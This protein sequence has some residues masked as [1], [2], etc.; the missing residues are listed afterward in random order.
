[1]QGQLQ[2]LTS[3]CILALLFSGCAK[4]KREPGVYIGDVNKTMAELSPRDVIISVNGDPLTRHEFE[5]NGKL[6]GKIWRILN[7][8]DSEPVEHAVRRREQQFIP[9]FIL[10]TMVK[11]EAK[12]RGITADPCD[13][14][15]VSTNFLKSIRR[16]GKTLQQVADEFSGEPGQKMIDMVNADALMQTLLKNLAPR[17][18]SITEADIDAAEKRIAEFDKNTAASNAVNLA[19]AKRVAAEVR[20]GGDIAA[21]AKRYSQINP[22]DGTLWGPL[23]KEQL[24]YKSPAVLAWAEKAKV[25]DVSDPLDVDDGLS[26]VKLLGRTV[27]GDPADPR[28]TEYRFAR[29]T[30]YVFEYHAKMTRDEI[31]NQLHKEAGETTREELVK[32]LWKT[33]VLEYPNGTNLFSE[34]ASPKTKTGQAKL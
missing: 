15:Q 1:M 30:L 17:R 7:P 24:K 27:D 6:Y 20:A 9:S 13:L 34:A 5:V 14:A 18:F 16:K 3:I 4:E 22:D 21:L 31:R 29:V 28:A 8:N 10:Q 23:D 2:Y 33:A 19:L 25:G 32:R 12:R 26:V 11:Q